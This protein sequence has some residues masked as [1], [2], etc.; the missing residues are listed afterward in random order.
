MVLGVP[1]LKQIR[2]YTDLVKSSSHDLSL[3]IPFR[4]ILYVLHA[5][6]ACRSRWK[7]IVV[8]SFVVPQLHGTDYTRH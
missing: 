4:I 6:H 8:K 2:V 3:S 7:G 1:I 5:S